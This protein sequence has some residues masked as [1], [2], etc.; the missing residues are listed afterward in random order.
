[1]YLPAGPSAWYDFYGEEVYA[2][3]AEA[4]V[5]AP[6]ERLPLL[7]AAG[8]MLPLTDDSE[9][10]KRLHDEPSRCLRCAPS[11]CRCMFQHFLFLWRRGS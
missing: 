4:T 9:D 8:A 3:G 2:A 10:F 5:P 11:G 6:L 1:V 7:V